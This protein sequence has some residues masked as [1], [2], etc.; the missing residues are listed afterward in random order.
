MDYMGT[1]QMRRIKDGEDVTNI[2]VI[3]GNH[4]PNLIS[5]IQQAKRAIQQYVEHPDIDVHD[6]ASLRI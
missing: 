1:F 6:R 5:Q 3:K 2:I 4:L